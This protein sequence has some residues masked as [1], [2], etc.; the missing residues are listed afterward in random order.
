MV[1]KKQNHHLPIKLT[2]IKQ[3]KTLKLSAGVSKK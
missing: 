1:I 2:E 3:N